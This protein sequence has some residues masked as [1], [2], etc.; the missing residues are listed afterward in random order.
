VLYVTSTELID[1]EGWDAD[2]L[3]L[4]RTLMGHKRAVLALC[5]WES[6]F[7]SG[8]RDGTIKIW[9]AETLHCIRTLSGHKDDVLS[10]AA[11]IRLLYSGGA[12]FSIRVIIHSERLC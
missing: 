8:S 4:K 12:D 7:Y 2:T 1:D 6:T 11:S 3:E 10:L 9:D 5:V